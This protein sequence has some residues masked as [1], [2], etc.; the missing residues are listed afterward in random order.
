M[1]TTIDRAFGEKFLKSI[2]DFYAY[3]VDWL[4]N[5]WWESAPAEEIGRAH[6]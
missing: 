1:Q 5:E 6:V 2:D 4:F 3:G